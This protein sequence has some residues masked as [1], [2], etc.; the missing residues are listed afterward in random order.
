MPFNHR[1]GRKQRKRLAALLATGQLSALPQSTPERQ[2]ERDCAA[3]LRHESVATAPVVVISVSPLRF[4]WDNIHFWTN[5]AH[6]WNRSFGVGQACYVWVNPTTTIEP[7]K[8]ESGTVRHGGTC[9]AQVIMINPSPHTYIHLC[10]HTAVVFFLIDLFDTALQTFF[11][12]IG[13]LMSGDIAPEVLSEVFAGCGAMTIGISGDFNVVRSPTGN[14][15]YAAG[16]D[17]L[18][19]QQL[20][21]LA[22]LVGSDYTVGLQGV[23]PV[24]AL[25]ILG[26]FSSKQQDQD[27]QGLLNGLNMF[28]DWLRSGIGMGPGKAALRSKLKNV[29]IHE[30]FPNMSVVD[31]YLHPQVNE[32]K[33]AFSWGTPDLLSLQNYARQNIL[34]TTKKTDE[35]L[36]P[37]LKRLSDLKA[38]PCG[39][40][41]ILSAGRVLCL[42]TKL[43]SLAFDWER[44]LFP[45]GPLG[46]CVGLFVRAYLGSVTPVGELVRSR[47]ET[48][49]TGQAGCPTERGGVPSVD[50]VN[51]VE[52]GLNYWMMTFGYLG[53][54]LV[55]VRQSTC[56]H[57]DSVGAGATDH[58]VSHSPTP[59]LGEQGEGPSNSGAESIPE[60]LVPP[61]PRKYPSQHH[62]CAMRRANPRL[63][64][65]PLMGWYPSV[66]ALSFTTLV[67]DWYMSKCY[68]RHKLDYVG[69]SVDWCERIFGPRRG[70]ILD[71]RDVSGRC[72]IQVHASALVLVMAS[73]GT[74]LYLVKPHRMILLAR[75]SQKTIDSYYKVDTVLL[76][77]DTKMS[78]RVQQAVQ[79]IGGESVNDCEEPR[80]KK[81]RRA[82]N[83]QVQFKKQNTQNV[84]DV[85]HD[86]THTVKN[87]ITSRSCDGENSNLPGTSESNVSPSKEFIPQREQ[88][89]VNSLKNK[90]K[91]IEVFRKSK[92]GL[93]QT[94]RDRRVKRQILK[95]A[96][97]SESSSESS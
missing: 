20:I 32:S 56:K 7:K 83:Q 4:A 55:G 96:Y 36:L 62:E 16:V 54:D 19:R 68:S 23:G 61:D 67:W 63:A 33:E 86:G 42:C 49:G 71:E 8:Q 65:Q 39:M 5:E 44:S 57:V 90:M 72:K 9:V 81:P 47:R 85:L 17:E 80:P 88:D 84:A 97:L 25:E 28:R 93:D 50:T 89:K 22:L 14:G 64:V 40:R 35:I 92:H 82:K 59:A 24:T 95:E 6:L 69:S 18:N 70:A 73:G 60:V 75:L 87:N 74:L 43:A 3:Q 13:E 66:W 77:A 1:H 79:R 11:I 41:L 31:A 27:I 78:K 94:K 38:R 37:V 30:G 46:G 10:T 15:K 12:K 91:A 58:A 34:W 48:R 51:V 29:H 76:A 26:V 21:L 52:K 45:L 53:S 2:A